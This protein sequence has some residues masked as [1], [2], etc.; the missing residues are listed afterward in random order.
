MFCENCGKKR[1][2]DEAFCESCGHP[3]PTIEHTE[4]TISK[5]ISESKIDGDD[6]EVRQEKLVLEKHGDITLQGSEMQWMYE[7]SFWRNPA[8]LITSAKVMLIALFVPAIFMFFITLSDGF[9]DA[10]SI[11]AMIL[12][13]GAIGFAILLIIAYVF[14]G[15]LYG[16]KYF[17]LFKLDDKGVN[18][19]Q[20]DKQYKK[21]QALGFLT[22]LI[23]L[24]SGNLTTAAS[25]LMAATKQSL[26]TSF[27]KVKS[28]KVVKSRHTIYIN[29][30]L[31][32][33][34]IY[35]TDDDFDFILEHILNNCPKNVK[36]TYK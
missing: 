20:L 11:S 7:F 2:A 31:T 5:E 32:R 17:V 13:Y 16:G 6:A 34:Q 28:I 18:H 12:A 33:N 24:S 35:V 36:V 22:A 15:I 23:G 26:Y 27:K 21:A 30:T 8:I 10:I 4:S 3:F 1:I 9:M 19:I 25:G 29:E 14:V